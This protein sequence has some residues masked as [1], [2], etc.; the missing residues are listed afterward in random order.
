MAITTLLLPGLA[1][2]VVLA[3][4]VWALST[5]VRVKGDAPIATMV[6]GLL[7]LL[8]FVLSLTLSSESSNLTSARSASSSEANA[9]G[10]LYWFAHGVHQPE[11]G[12]LQGLLRDYV[13]VV[14]HEEWP[15]LAQHKSSPAASAAVRAIRDN[16]IHYTPRTPKEKI[17]YPTALSNVSQLFNYRRARVA[18]AVS[19]GVPAVLIDAL[20]FLTA[21]VLI[22]LP[23]AGAMKHARDLCLYGLFATLFVATLFFVNDLNNPF[24]GAVRIAPDD[25]NNLFTGLFVHVR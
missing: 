20:I 19:P 17:F 5:R 23:L 2:G 7:F 16:L 9:V 14:A 13:T 8:A 18:I 11:H 15:L 10:E 24:A 12:K 22:A 25:F 6:G 21:L 1:I 4:G 3:V